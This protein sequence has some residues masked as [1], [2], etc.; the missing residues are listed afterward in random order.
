MYSPPPDLTDRI[1]ILRVHTKQM[2]LSMDVTLERIAD[3]TDAYSGTQCISARVSLTQSS[4]WPESLK[5]K[6][7]VP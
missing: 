3:E 2:P 6:V 7:Q 5:V 1:A 4:I